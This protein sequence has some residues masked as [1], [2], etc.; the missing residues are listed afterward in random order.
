ME[1]TTQL[2]FFRSKINHHTGKHA[3]AATNWVDVEGT[4]A[5]AHYGL[6]PTLLHVP[7]SFYRR[8]HK[9]KS[10]QYSCNFCISGV[11]CLFLVCLC[12]WLHDS[13]T[14]F[15]NRL[16]FLYLPHFHEPPSI[17]F[18]TIIFHIP[19]LYLLIFFLSY[20]IYFI[21]ANTYLN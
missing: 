8:T 3:V 10:I 19:K 14:H 16:I 4:R 1:R 21:H 13:I 2:S 17:T 18:Y 11:N 7:I 6:L 12:F 5:L 9:A 15:V 20:S